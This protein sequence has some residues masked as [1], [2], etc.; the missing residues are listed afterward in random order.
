[1]TKT[2]EIPRLVPSEY[3]VLKLTCKHGDTGVPMTRNVRVAIRSAAKKNHK[4]LYDQPVDTM[5]RYGFRKGEKTKLPVNTLGR[6]VFGL[7]GFRANLYTVA[8]KDTLE[9]YLYTDNAHALMM[10]AGALN[11]MGLEVLEISTL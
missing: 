10:I 2:N 6:F 4:V 8:L 5:G 11:D 9:V 7:S 1:M 3:P